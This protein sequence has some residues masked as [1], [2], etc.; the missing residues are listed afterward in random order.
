MV[1]EEGV[2]E[3]GIVSM[4]MDAVR[5]W[6]PLHTIGLPEEFFPAHLSVALIDAL[7][8]PLPGREETQKAGDRYCHRFG[9][10]RTR[11]DAW[12]LP[13]VAEQETFRD[14]MR[15]F[16]E[17]G[18]AAMAKVLYG[19]N[20]G[21]IGGAAESV[22]SVRVAAE[23]LLDTG[24][25]HLQRAQYRSATKIAA[26]LRTLQAIDAGAIRRLLMYTGDDEFVYGDVFVRGFV[27]GA[28][29]RRS[30][31][32]AKAKAYVRAVAYELLLAPRFLDYRIWEH[33]TSGF[34]SRGHAVP[35]LSRRGGGSGGVFPAAWRGRR[36]SSDGIAAPPSGTI[37][38]GIDVD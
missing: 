26:T 28:P 6:I 13:P 4:V 8:Q 10:A 21:A 29:N 25:A 36:Q 37:S 1:M 7:V 35:A 33:G 23:A 19:A 14:L 22:E 2:V 38:Y 15:R 20:H 9:L 32:A 12:T 11:E 24:V 34:A 17:L 18:I 3:E 31:P 27:A 30:I 5:F 16:E